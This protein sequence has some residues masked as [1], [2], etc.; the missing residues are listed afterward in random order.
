[1]ELL[2]TMSSHVGES[3]VGQGF[4][5]TVLCRALLKVDYSDSP[6]IRGLAKSEILEF[7]D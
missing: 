4:T 1:M 7:W 6:V 5:G 3:L 2:G